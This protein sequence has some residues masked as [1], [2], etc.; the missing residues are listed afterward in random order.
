MWCYSEWTL[1]RAEICSGFHKGSVTRSD[2]PGVVSVRTYR[3]IPR[4]HC[5]SLGSLTSEILSGAMSSVAWMLKKEKLVK[6]FKQQSLMCPVPRRSF[7]VLLV[8]V[9]TGAVHGAEPGFG[10]REEEAERYGR[11]QISQ[12]LLWTQR[13]TVVGGHQVKGTVS[14]VVATT[15]WIGNGWLHCAVI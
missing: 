11:R 8:F 14:T 9:T 3:F 10:E 13:W 1:N 15:Q 4:V 2:W 6:P 7:A 5:F 12:G